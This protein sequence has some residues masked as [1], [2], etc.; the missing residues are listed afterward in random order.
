[1]STILRSGG[2]NGYAS[3]RYRWVVEFAVT[4]AAFPPYIGGL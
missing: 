3:L 1:M 2:T 4:T